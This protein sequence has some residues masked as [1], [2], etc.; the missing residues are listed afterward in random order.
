MLAFRKLIST[1]RSVHRLL[2][3][4]TFYDSQSG[5]MI[6]VGGSCTLHDVTF[7]ASP[8]NEFQDKLQSVLH[9]PLLE[10]LQVM[11]TDSRTLD[12][13]TLLKKED[14]PMPDI[15]LKADSLPEIHA[16]KDLNIK[17][18]GYVIAMSTQS[19]AL[20]K[21]EHLAMLKEAVDGEKK[22]RVMLTTD[23]SESGTEVI[24]TGNVIGELCDIG[25]S[26]IILEHH[27]DHGAVIDA[28]KVRQTIEEAFYLDISGSPINQRLGLMTRDTESMDTAIE[29]GCIHYVTNRDQDQSLITRL[30]KDNQ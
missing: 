13:I 30:L 21:E 28:D 22:V 2:T 7:A 16:H 14:K 1:P 19:S 29:L 6:S 15:F 20:E 9:N 12:T 10:S 27:N 23:L 8:V 26:I 18:D 5:G 11:R 17:V 25:A 24:A 3:T 4:K